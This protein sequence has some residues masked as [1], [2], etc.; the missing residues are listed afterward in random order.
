MKKTIIILLS[1]LAACTYGYAQKYLGGD[2]SLLPTYEKNGT[3]FK[4]ENGERSIGFFP[5]TRHERHA[6]APFR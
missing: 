1:A 5:A 3:V 4:N 6:R 2:I